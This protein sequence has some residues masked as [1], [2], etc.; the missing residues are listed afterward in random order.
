MWNDRFHKKPYFTSIN[1][2][3]VVVLCHDN[4]IIIK[5]I[6]FIT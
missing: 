2:N 6:K 1:K 3:Y 4:I 5:S